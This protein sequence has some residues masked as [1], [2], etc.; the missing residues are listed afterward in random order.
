MA[1]QADR[2]GKIWNIATVMGAWQHV[3]SVGRRDDDSMNSLNDLVKV[4]CNWNDGCDSYFDDTYVVHLDNVTLTATPADGPAST[5][6]GTESRVDGRDRLIATHETGLGTT[7]GTVA[8]DWRP[9]HDAADGVAFAE[10]TSDDAYIIALY[11]DADDFVNVYWDAPNIIRMEYSMGGATASGTWNAAGVITRGTQYAVQLDYTGLGNMTL[12]IG[13]ITR[14]TL[15]SIPAAFGTAPDDVFHGSDSTGANQGDATFANYPTA[16]TLTSFEARGAD[17]AVELR[18]ET[19]SELDNLGFHLYRATSEHGSYLRVTT[20][21]IPGLGSS[22]VGARYLY[23]DTGLSPGTTYYYELEDIETSGKTK[24]HGP[25]S[26][27]ALSGAPAGDSEPPLEE[28]ERAR[29]TYGD[30]AANHFRV[31]RHRRDGVVLELVTEGFYATPQE[32]GTVRIQV[33][34]FTETESAS[35]PTKRVWIEALAGRKVRLASVQT[36]MVEV[37][38]GLRPSPAGSLELVA[39]R[40]GTVRAERRRHSGTRRAPG[41]V[42]LPEAAHLVSVAFQGDVKK[43]L[44][45]LAP[46]RWDAN[47]GALVLARRLVVRI[48]F[49]EPEPTEVVIEGSRGRRPGKPKSLHNRALVARLATTQ[50]GLYALRYEDVFGRSRRGARAYEV[51]LS[52]LGENVAYHLEPDRQRFAPGSTLYFISKGAE[53]NPYGHEAVYELEAGAAGGRMSVRDAAPKGQPIDH[54]WEIVRREENHLYQAGLLEAPDRWLWDLLLAPGTKRYGFDVDSL[55]SV[56]VPARL[57]L[58]LQGASDLGASPDHHVRAYV[59]GSLI[60]E[61]SWDGKR[62]RRLEAEIGPGVLRDGGN[63][64]EIENVGDTGA[65]YSMVLL[66]RFEVQYPRHVVARPGRA[67]EGWWDRPGTT[68]VHTSRPEAFVLDTTGKSPQW[69]TG[70]ERSSD[71]WLRFRSEPGRNYFV[72]GSSDVLR[73]VVRPARPSRWKSVRHGANYLAVGPRKLL[74]MAHPLLEHRR[75]Q[76]LNV[77]AAATV[78]SGRDLQKIY[79]S[80]LGAAATREAILQSFDDGASLVSYVGHGGIHVWASEKILSTGDAALLSAQPRQPL[81]LTMNC[82]N[83]YFHFP[84]FDSL[85][86]D[87]LEAEDKGIIAAFSPSGLSLDRPAQELHRALLSELVSGRH[88]R[89]GDAILVAQTKFLE[90]GLSPELLII[91]HL[92]G[93]PA[94]VLR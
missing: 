86:E 61:G 47:E 1:A 17:H 34:G 52:R 94:L 68:T 92:L 75:R 16:V 42:S 28:D 10:T 37:V 9:R 48:S 46:I 64:L 29:I 39:T 12:M 85:A 36:R 44:V 63:Q 32:D 15:A 41:N 43:A 78:L 60:G 13:G 87:L 90:T 70:I 18:W 74:E 50:R 45:E 49:R 2:D 67:L 11:G 4:G 58:W 79:L 56:S 51:R 89:L 8:F 77:A 82:L 59:N 53:A 27:A 20:S 80:R 66:N 22:P 5:E 6:N 76:G 81:L 19:A 7:S 83:G 23:R 35:V 21:V 72:A 65:A 73:P 71:G 93:D 62:E 3:P 30:P 26:A 55:A 88:Q 91:Y 31:L 69:L 54:Y 84:Y 24:R 40:Q 38:S 57:T 33:P 14:I 25:V